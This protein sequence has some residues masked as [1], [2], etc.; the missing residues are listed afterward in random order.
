MRVEG[1]VQGRERERELLGRGR[2]GREELHCQCRGRAT[3]GRKMGEE[4]A[5][6]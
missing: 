3:G 1:E 5:A 6:W 4:R 2:S